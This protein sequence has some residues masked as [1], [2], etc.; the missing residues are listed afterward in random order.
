MADPSNPTREREVEMN[1]TP[2][3]EPTAQRISRLGLIHAGETTLKLRLV[4]DT[5]PS[6]DYASSRVDLVAN[7]CTSVDYTPGGYAITFTPGG[8]TADRIAY[9]V[10]GALGFI[11]IDASIVNNIVGAWIDNGSLALGRV[12]FPS[13]VPLDAVGKGILCVIYDGYPPG[14]IGIEVV[15]P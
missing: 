14:N 13:P 4:Q 1:S 10:S 7:E 15:L 8:L 9:E 6:I 5:L 11:V 2:M 12:E 3:E